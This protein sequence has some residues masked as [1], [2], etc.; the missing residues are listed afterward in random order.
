MEYNLL[1]R[2]GITKEEWESLLE[3]QGNKCAICRRGP[4]GFKNHARLFVDHDHAT[5]RIRGLLC[6]TC[7]SGLGHFKD[8]PD[9]LRMA[10]T[11]L[12]VA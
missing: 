6:G 11:Y 8:S 2:Y 4:E 1:R 5:G 12:E 10:A 9:L 7:N 3:T